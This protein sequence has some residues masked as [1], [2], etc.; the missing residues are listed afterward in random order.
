M[1]DTFKQIFIKVKYHVILCLTAT[2]ERLDGKHKIL[3]QIAPI[4]DRISIEEAIENKWLSPFK[5]YKVL[6]AVCAYEASVAIPLSS[7]TISL[8]LKERD[9]AKREIL[10]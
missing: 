2:M 1:A 4:I 9:E 5:E 3:E 6:L 10:S 7:E 8:R